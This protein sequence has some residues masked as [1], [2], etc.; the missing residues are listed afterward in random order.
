MSRSHDLRE[1]L[2]VSEDA[3]YCSYDDDELQAAA[4]LK[5]KRQR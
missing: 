5:R 4:R 3:E 2:L 1:P